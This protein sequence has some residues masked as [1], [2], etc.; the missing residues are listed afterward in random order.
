VPVRT[1]L[2]TDPAIRALKCPPEVL[3]IEETIRDPKLPGL[4][5]RVYRSGR[6]VFFLVYRFNREKKRLKLGL[7]S[8]PGFGLAAARL[9]ASDKL[10]SITKGEDPAAGVARAR[11]A[12]D[13]RRLYEE[14]EKEVVTNFPPKTRANWKGT[15]RRFL[16]EIGPLPVTATEEICDRVMALHKHV[17]LTEGKETLAHTIF[18]HTSRFF[19]WAIAERKLKPSQFALSGLR[20]RFKEKKR[21]RY[22]D[23]IEVRAVFRAIANPRTWWPE[24]VKPEDVTKRDKRRAVVHRCYFLL[25][26]Y[27]GCR[28]GALA[29]MRWSEI[30]PDHVD[31]DAWLWYRPTSKNSEPLEIPLSSHARTVL[32]ELRAMTG[33]EGF[34]FASQRGDGKTGHRSDS[35]KPVERLRAASG[36]ADFTNHAVRKTISTYLTRTLD[37]PTDVVT[38]ILNHRLPGPKANENYI[39]AL[40]VRRMRDA[41]EAWGQHLDRIVGNHE[42]SSPQATRQVGGVVGPTPN[43]TR[44]R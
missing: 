39:Q 35:W 9:M 44:A 22:Y 10:A 25:L 26:W 28:R 13:V 37:V 7:Y 8:P 20:S 33:D 29:S 15:S 12:D 6:K 1:E 4:R 18:K 17:G 5:I 36:I 14:F 24:G 21:T 27:V 43:M 38:A 30:K 3:F 23:P 41:L 42:A 19:R 40:P 32:D 11:R 16:A 31:P 34:V 2:R